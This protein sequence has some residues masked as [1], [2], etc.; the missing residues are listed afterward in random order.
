MRQATAAALTVEMGA[1]SYKATTMERLGPI[2][3]GQAIAA[4]AVVLLARSV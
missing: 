4:E 3:E 1:V 2:G